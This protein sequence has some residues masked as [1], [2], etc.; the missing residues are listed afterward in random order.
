[1]GI[2]LTF[3][4]TWGSLL[5]HDGNNYGHMASDMKS[6]ERLMKTNAS[7]LNA[8]KEGHLTCLN[9]CANHFIES[10][11]MCPIALCYRVISG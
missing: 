6:R 11:C 1:M 5:S 9:P 7:C 8:Y 3:F 2:L 10:N 4:A